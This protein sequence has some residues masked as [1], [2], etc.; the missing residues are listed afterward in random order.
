MI[1]QPLRGTRLWHF[2][3]ASLAIKEVHRLC[4]NPELCSVPSRDHASIRQKT[5]ESLPFLICGSRKRNNSAHSW[6]NSQFCKRNLCLQCLV[7][8]LDQLTL[9]EEYWAFASGRPRCRAHKLWRKAIPCGGKASSQ[10][11]HSLQLPHQ[12]FVDADPWAL[13][14]DRSKPALNPNRIVATALKCLI[15][16]WIYWRACQFH[17]WWFRRWIAL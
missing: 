17:K 8:N 2:V 5:L 15:K 4:P 12:N 16:V 3:G 9:E 6:T 13:G 14:A 11:V 1:E 7:A 10:L